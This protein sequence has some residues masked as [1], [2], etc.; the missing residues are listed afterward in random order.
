MMAS[1]LRAA[2]QRASATVV[3]VEMTF[4]PVA[5]TRS[6]SDSSGKPKWKLTTRG[7]M[8]STSRQ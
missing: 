4:A 5:R 1:H 2:S 3:A 8:S 7:S 6:N